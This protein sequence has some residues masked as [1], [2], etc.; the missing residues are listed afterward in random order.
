MSISNSFHARNPGQLTTMRINLQN[1]R[2]NKQMFNFPDADLGQKYY[3]T[4]AK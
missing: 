2:A 4:V 1:D 3:R